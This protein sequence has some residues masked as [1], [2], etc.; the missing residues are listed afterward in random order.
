MRDALVGLGVTGLVAAGVLA[1]RKKTRAAAA[2]PPED[3]VFALPAEP[4]P[5]KTMVETIWDNLDKIGTVVGGTPAVVGA[6][7][8][9]VNSKRIRERGKDAVA[10]GLGDDALAGFGEMT[11]DFDAARGDVTDF[12]DS[13]DDG[14]RRENATVFEHIG[15]EFVEGT[16]HVANGIVNGTID[17]T[18]AIINA[19]AQTIGEIGAAFN[20]PDAT[21]GDKAVAVFKS[22]QLVQDAAANLVVDGLGGTIVEEFVPAEKQEEATK[23]LDSI[24]N[25]D[26]TV[27]SGFDELGAAAAPEFQAID[28]DFQDF[29][30]ELEAIFTPAPPPEPDPPLATE[31]EVQE[32]IKAVTITSPVTDTVTEPSPITAIIT[33]TPVPKPSVPPPAPAPDLGKNRAV[34]LKHV[35]TKGCGRSFHIRLSAKVGE[36]HEFRLRDHRNNDAY[37]IKSWEYVKKYR[38]GGPQPKVIDGL[39]IRVEDGRDVELLVK[40]KKC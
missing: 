23:V 17:G 13:W 14:L 39:K 4:E 36:R 35:D 12:T 33:Q 25:F 37:R 28:D 5:P 19:G 26:K 30:N 34:V 10:A 11:G 15:A 8:T 9:A 16:G 40:I 7:G 24:S 29:G 2:A 6:V 1:S 21:D 38:G 18:E 3:E 20:D 32:L 22:T 31:A 27:A